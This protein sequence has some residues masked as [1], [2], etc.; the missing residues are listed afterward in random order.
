ML[1]AYLKQTIIV[2]EPP[3]TR[4]AYLVEKSS[5]YRLYVQLSE[6]KAAFLFTGYVLLAGI[7]L[8]STV[9]HV[10][11]PFSTF[12]ALGAIASILGAFFVAMIAFEAPL[13][14]LAWWRPGRSVHDKLRYS[15]LRHAN[16]FNGDLKFNELGTA[17]EMGQELVDELQQLAILHDERRNVLR[18][19]SWTGLTALALTL[20][21]VLPILWK[22]IRF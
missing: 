11:N 7:N 6:Q 21:G 13:I 10:S 12:R 5:Q 18:L 19:S 14:R 2:N 3:D 16:F 1:A 15:P 9:P 8:S 20:M 4:F 17:P 22:L